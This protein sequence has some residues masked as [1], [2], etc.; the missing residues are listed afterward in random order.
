MDRRVNDLNHG[1]LKEET[2]QKVRKSFFHSDFPA[3][4]LNDFFDQ[5][6]YTELKKKILSLNFKRDAVILHHS[7]AISSYKITSKEFCDF[8]SFITK[9]KIDEITFSAYLLTWKDYMILNDK[10]LQKPGI[11]VII[12]LTD[13]WNAELGGVVTFTDGK[14]TVYPI[15]PTENSLAIVERKKNLQK[16][17]QYIN[18]YAKDKKRLLL[19]AS[20]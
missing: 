4:L 15:T 5:G 17:I 10:Y 8:I 20:I 1:Y 14:G 12:D 13:N 11:D 9:K 6:F 7:Y 3:I 18:H 19:I 16:Y 2:K